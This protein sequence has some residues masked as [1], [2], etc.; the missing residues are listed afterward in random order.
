MKRKWRREID[1][2]CKEGE[3]KKKEL[4]KKV[5]N[6]EAENRKRGG[7]ERKKWTWKKRT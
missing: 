6:G 2:E 1:E 5:Y 4:R 3:E 7:E